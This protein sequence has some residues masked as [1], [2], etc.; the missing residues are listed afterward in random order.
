VSCAIFGGSRATALIWIMYGD[1]RLPDGAERAGI[2]RG[3]ADL[4]AYFRF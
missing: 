3:V 1:P 2:S 4:I